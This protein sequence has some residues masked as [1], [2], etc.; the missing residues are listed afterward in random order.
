MRGTPPKDPALRQRR[1]KQP[2]AAKLRAD[3]DAQVP[4]LPMDCVW[5]PETIAE[6]FDIWRSPM[7]SQFIEA[8]FHGLLKLARLIDDFWTADSAS[9]RAKLAVEIRLQRAD[10]GLNPISRN[11]LHWEIDRG[12]QAQER[13]AKRRQRQETPPPTPEQDPRA[14]L[15]RQ[16]GLV[17]LAGGKAS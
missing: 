4:P 14:V 12:E 5:A 9:M 10:F 3:P 7:A 2:S 6:W 17:A 8:D 13:S 1:N 16:G 11:R 15:G